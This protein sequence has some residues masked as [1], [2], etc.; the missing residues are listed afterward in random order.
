MRR[1]SRAI[2]IRDEKLLVMHRNKF[3]TEYYTLPGGNIEVGESPEEA[4]LRELQEE[5]MVKVDSPKFVILEHSGD[6]YGDQYIFKCNYVSGEP[7]LS[8]DAEEV[9]INK[10][11]RN[12][13]KPMW[14]SMIDLQTSSFVSED[15]KKLVI[16]YHNNGWPEAAVEITTKY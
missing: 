7:Q 14:L 12:L 8:P 3:G 2:V 4:L 10:L 9:A 15:L 16:K 6:P 1:A 13:Y 11:G 5:T